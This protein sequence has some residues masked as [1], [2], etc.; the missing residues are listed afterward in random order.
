M[1]VIRLGAHDN[2]VLRM[3]ANPNPIILGSGGYGK[4]FTTADYPDLA[5]KVSLDTNVCREWRKE[6]NTQKTIYENYDSKN[7][8]VRVV[9]PIKFAFIEGD[10]CFILM[11]RVCPPKNMEQNTAIQAMMGEIERDDTHHKRGRFVGRSFLKDYIDLDR[12]ALDMGIFLA[13]V[14]FKLGYDAGDL[15][16][17]LGRRCGTD[18][19]YWINVVDFGLVNEYTRDNAALSIYAQAYFPL[20]SF[21]EYAECTAL[22][23]EQNERLSKIFAES[24]ISEAEKYGKGEEAAIVLELAQ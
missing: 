3:L 24:Y 19:K 15:E 12:V 14:H 7:K 11:Q 9:K 8:A 23:A 10:R 1:E 18:K 13:T 16:Y 22:Q 17:I 6:F 2:I 20:A 4:V 21:C 5:L